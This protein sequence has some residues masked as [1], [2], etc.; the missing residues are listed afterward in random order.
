MIEIWD[1]TDHH[2][3]SKIDFT[4]LS[5]VKTFVV[6]TDTL[7]TFVLT[8]NGKHSVLSERVENQKSPCAGLCRCNPQ[9]LRQVYLHRQMSWQIFI[10]PKEIRFTWSPNNIFNE[11]SSGMRDATA[12]RHFLRMFM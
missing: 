5:S 1:V 8:A 7:R 12:I 4:D 6:D 2:S 9:L 3:A 10:D 11:F